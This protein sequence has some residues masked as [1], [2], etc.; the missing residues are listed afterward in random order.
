M[1]DMLQGSGMPMP[2]MGSMFGGFGAP[3]HPP[4]QSHNGSHDLFSAMMPQGFMSPMSMM[5]MNP[6]QNMQNAL[7]MAHN[8][9]NGGMSYCSSSVTSYTRDEQGRMQ[10]YQQSN[11][12]KQGPDGLKETKSAVRDS[13][14][15]HQELSIGHHLKEKAHIKKKSKN[16]Y[17]NEQEEC[18]DFVGIDETEA[19]AFEQNWQRQAQSFAHNRNPYEQ[20][21]YNNSSRSSRNNNR[22]ALT[23]SANEDQLIPPVPHH[24]HHNHNH[25]HSPS[26]RPSGLSSIIDKVAMKTKKKKKSKESKY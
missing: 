1:R 11:E 21:Q 26:H 6:F 9:S 12:V 10:V 25:N 3:M 7:S 8:G 23:S 18:E 15:G 22:L 13:R 4:M 14:T 24:H 16:A 2:F 5:M 19:D 20:L 17:T